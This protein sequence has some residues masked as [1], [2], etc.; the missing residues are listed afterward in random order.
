MYWKEI[1]LG[2]QILLPLD[3]TQ[4]IELSKCGWFSGLKLHFVATNAAKLDAT[5]GERIVDHL[6]RIKITDGK[7]KTL[8]SLTGQEIKALNFYDEGDVFPE[9]YINIA[10]DVQ[11][12]TIY[13]PFGRFYKDPDYMLQADPW[14]GLWL[15]ITND[16][17]DSIF[18]DDSLMMDIIP[19]EAMELKRGTTHWI[20]PFEWLTQKPTG[21]GQVLSMELPA[22]DPIHKVM[23]QLDPDLDAYG[24]PKN[25]PKVDTNTIKLL[26]EEMS[27]TA[28]EMRPLDLMRD[29][30][31][32]YGRP[33]TRGR[34]H[35]VAGVFNDLKL[36]L[37]ESITSCGVYAEA[38]TAEVWQQED[39]WGRYQSTLLTL[40]DQKYEQWDAVGYGLYH[41]MMLWDSL[42]TQ[43]NEVL[44]LAC[45][46]NKHSPAHIIFEPT[47]DD[48]TMRTII[49]TVHR[50]G[51]I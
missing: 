18:S 27:V 29:N 5:M 2:K 1:R 11:Q 50:Q 19:V 22:M 36:A 23:I 51:E 30:A 33:H 10:Q 34:T 48:F 3:S 43:G 39:N 42:K 14:C 26:F 12:T 4:R 25:D 44:E 28:L 24:S 17:T 7:G 20:K 31:I 32:E 46:C 41:T 15:E 35:F 6:T 38:A 47:Y 9:Q 21:P 8:I 37:I 45:G 16:A 49:K 13:L 40:T